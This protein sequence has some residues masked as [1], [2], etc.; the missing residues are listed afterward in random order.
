MKVQVTGVLGGDIGDLG[1]QEGWG[2]LLG[3][4]IGRGAAGGTGGN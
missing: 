4:A 1:R 2:G 3:Q